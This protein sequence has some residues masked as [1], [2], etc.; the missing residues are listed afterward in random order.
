[1]PWNTLKKTK[2]S[3][4][5][6]SRQAAV[7]TMNRIIDRTSGPL[8]PYLSLAGP[9]SSWPEASPTMLDVRLSCTH[10]VVVPK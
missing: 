10:D 2:D 5:Q 7:E 4:F 6:A 9:I 3:M 8:R 1:M